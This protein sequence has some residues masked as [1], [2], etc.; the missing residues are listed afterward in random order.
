VAVHHPLAGVRVIDL[1]T[2]LSG[3]LATHTLGE[4]GAEVIKVEP[5]AGDPTRAGSGLAPGDPPSPFWLAL[6]RDRLSVTLDL[7]SEAGRGVLLD[8]VAHADVLLENFRPGV[9]ARLG[10]TYDELR[11]V[12]PRLIYCSITGYGSEGPGAGR[13]A[14]DGPVQAATGVLELTGA[15]GDGPGWPLPVTIADVAG[16]AAAAQATAAALYA[17][18]RTGAGCHLDLSLAECLLQWL[19]VA[20]RYGSLAPPTT[21]VVE[22]SDGRALLVQTPLHFHAR[23][24]ALV[25]E[26]PGCATFAGDP[27]WATAEGRLVGV[28]DYV[29]GMRRAFASGPADEWLARLGAAGIPAAAVRTLDEALGDPQLAYRGATTTVDVPGTG[30]VQV[31]LGPFL[32]DGARRG[33]TALPPTLGQHNEAVLRDLLGYD[34]DRLAR[35]RASGAW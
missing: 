2:F 24:L 21:L 13:P 30:P 23:L 11:T 29:A 20:D 9:T 32:V 28:G 16:A 12:N 4:L 6:H 34:D 17:R 27:R 5:P 7:K 22:S 26:I 15:R 33:E 31:L 10:V 1:S 3:P 35:L 14:T 18:E 8:L 19:A 25:A